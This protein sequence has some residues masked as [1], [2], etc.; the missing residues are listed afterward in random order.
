MGYVVTLH[1]YDLGAGQLAGVGSH[2]GGAFHAA[3]EINGVEWSYGGAD[4]GTGVFSCEPRGCTMHRYKESIAM[5][6]TAMGPKDVDGLVQQ[7]SGEWPGASYDLLHRNCCHFAEGF[8]VSLGVGAI[9]TWVNRAAKT[10]V[11]SLAINPSLLVRMYGL[12]WTDFLWFVGSTLT[13]CLRLQA[14]LIDGAE[15]LQE[16]AVS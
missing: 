9:P 7:M 12:V 5:G 1:V 11:S 10:G 14:G 16:R 6:E 4:A 2:V 3:V 8:C 15:D 13:D